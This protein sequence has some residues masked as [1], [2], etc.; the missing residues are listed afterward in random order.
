[1]HLPVVTDS[2]ISEIV[3]IPRFS[4]CFYDDVIISHGQ[5][6]LF[7]KSHDKDD[8]VK[9]ITEIHEPLNEANFQ[10]GRF[11]KAFI[12]DLRSKETGFIYLAD[13]EEGLN[14][15]QELYKKG[16]VFMSFEV[17]AGIFE[18]L[19]R[20]GV[21]IVNAIH[22]HPNL[23][24]HFID[25]PFEMKAQLHLSVQVDEAGL[26]TFFRE[27]IRV[28]H[29][30]AGLRAALL[31]VKISRL[32]SNGLQKFRVVKVLFDPRK[33]SAWNHELVLVC[34]SSLLESRSVNKFVSSP[35]FSTLMANRICLSQGPTNYKNF[36]NLLGVLSRV[37][38]PRTNY[39]Y[40]ALA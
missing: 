4:S 10:L 28:L 21:F 14:K 40:L 26:F 6:H 25:V 22:S 32:L 12:S 1:M 23:I 39:S 11:C 18:S 33:V 7:L 34:A 15:W 16:G 20:D 17:V 24:Q 27:F 5:Y 38:D 13:A 35:S 29:F 36:L 3:A 19:G 37:Y 9:F 30:D 8:S 31:D 2:I